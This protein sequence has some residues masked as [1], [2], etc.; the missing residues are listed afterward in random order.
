[1]S[2]NAKKRRRKKIRR[3]I[4]IIELILLM[5]LGGLLYVYSKFGK[6]NFNDLGKVK[7]NNLDKKTKDL[8]SGY[9][10][11]ALYGVDTRVMGDYKNSHSDSIIV[12]VIDNKRKNS[13]K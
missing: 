13:V 1:M 12:C 7:T 2:L 9:T 10:T 8:L 6:M 3:I 5:M 4:L 11:I